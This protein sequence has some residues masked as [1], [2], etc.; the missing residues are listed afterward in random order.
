VIVAAVVLA[1]VAGGVVA[2]QPWQQRKHDAIIDIV[3]AGLD[4]QLT[5]DHAPIVGRHLQLP[6]S[7][8]AHVLEFRNKWG[9]RVLR[10]IADHDQTLDASSAMIVR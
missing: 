1:L 2:W 7:K 9:V 10:F 4:T 8:E 6:L 3:H 5:L